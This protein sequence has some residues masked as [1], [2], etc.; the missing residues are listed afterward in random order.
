MLYKGKSSVARQP[1]VVNSRAAKC[2]YSGAC[3]CVPKGRREGERGMEPSQARANPVGVKRVAG[4]TGERSQAPGALLSP[5]R[6]P[7]NV[8]GH[9]HSLRLRSLIPYRSEVARDYMMLLDFEAGEPGEGRVTEY[10][11]FPFAFRWQH[12]GIECEYIPDLIYVSSGIAAL[13]HCDEHPAWQSYEERVG[14]GFATAWCREH[15][16]ELEVVTPSQLRATPYVSNIRLLRG[17][18]RLEV[19]PEDIEAAH[20]CL[21]AAGGPLSISTLALEIA[22]PHV[23]Y[24]SAVVLHMSYH[25]MLSL[26]LHTEEISSASLV[27][28]PS[29]VLEKKGLY[30]S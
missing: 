25:H 7:D 1:G 12:S 6:Y 2:L 5:V 22:G 29:I 9:W 17:F 18:A 3:F 24:G 26:P 23:S 13:V 10:R 19:P 8:I 21:D 16:C 28:L 30:G 14:L 4:E 11:A 15:G 27:G 20:R